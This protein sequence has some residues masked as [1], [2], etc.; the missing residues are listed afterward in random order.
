M[1]SSRVQVRTQIYSLTR[2]H[3]GLIRWPSPTTKRYRR[4]TLR[5]IDLPSKEESS[6]Q[7]HPLGSGRQWIIQQ[8]QVW[9]HV[10]CERT[11]GKKTEAS[12]GYYCEH[13]ASASCI[14]FLQLTGYALQVEGIGEPL[15]HLHDVHIINRND[16]F[17]ANRYQQSTFA[18]NAAH[19]LAA[20]RLCYFPGHS[21]RE[22]STSA[23][24]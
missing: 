8:D 12:G 22:T 21:S 19:L 10:R 16:C 11:G 1:H 9:S 7:S 5:N 15:L 2:V 20:D 23:A 24:N 18:F 17:T 3:R 4:Y 14:S 6:T 13:F